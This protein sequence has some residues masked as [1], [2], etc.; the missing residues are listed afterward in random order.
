MK[1][2][3][4]K[5]SI[6]FV[7]VAASVYLIFGY[8]SSYN[9]YQ[10]AVVELQSKAQSAVE[11]AYSLDDPPTKQTVAD[12]VRISAERHLEESFILPWMIISLLLINFLLIW[13]VT[14]FLRRTEG[15]STDDAS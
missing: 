7:S 14:L 8:V 2:A 1:A 4:K 13:L 11:H 6:I 12:L 15:D 5:L 10:R 9:D 3:T